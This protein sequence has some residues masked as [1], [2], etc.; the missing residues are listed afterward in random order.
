MTAHSQPI[1]RT[2]QCQHFHLAMSSEQGD[3]SMAAGWSG[4]WNYTFGEQHALLARGKAVRRTVGRALSGYGRKGYNAT[5]R[6]L[7]NGNVGGTALKDYR[8]VAVQSPNDPMS[9]GG[10][11]TTE[12]KVVINRA[13]TAN[14]I[15]IITSDLDYD[16]SPAPWPVDKSGNGGGGKGGGM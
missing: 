3:T 16:N 13:T 11:R 4:M 15:A 5:L 10:V 7:V 9:L 8:R 6:Q 1:L 14:D 12:N 2:P